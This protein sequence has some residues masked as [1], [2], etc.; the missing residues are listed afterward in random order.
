MLKITRSTRK[1]DNWDT[2]YDDANLTLAHLKDM[3]Y[4][5]AN[6]PSHDIIYGGT[7]IHIEI[8]GYS[9]NV[10]YTITET[11]QEQQ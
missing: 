5:V 8:R 2:S 3:I 1:Q 11:E 9:R 4:E 6:A 10:R 7:R